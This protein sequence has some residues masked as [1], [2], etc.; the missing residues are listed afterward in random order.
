MAKISSHGATTLVQVKAHKD[1]HGARTHDGKIHLTITAT[2]DGRVLRQVSMR[3]RGN[4]PGSRAY[5]SRSANK[6]VA[7]VPTEELSRGAESVR[8][9][10]ATLARK[11]G[12]TIDE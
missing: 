4:L 6:L 11:W 8:P 12:Y 1:D 10:L 2:T 3:Y 5:S 7:R 9:I